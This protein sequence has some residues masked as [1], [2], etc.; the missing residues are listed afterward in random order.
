[1]KFVRWS[2]ALIITAAASATFAD[3]LTLQQAVAGALENN[4]QVRIA[5]ARQ[6]QAIA[7]QTE[8]R[9]MWLPH[10]DVSETL[11]STNN[12]VYV[13][14]SLLEQGR[15]GAQNFDPHFLNQPPVSR[16]HRLGLKVRYTV[17]D[18]FRRLETTRQAA[19][20][21]AQSKSGVDETSQ[22][23]RLDVI[24]K[25]YG[26]LVAQARH[27]VALDAV[28]TAEHDAQSMREKFREGLL[29]ESDALAAE[30]QVA[31]FRQ[32]EIEAAGGVVIARAALN[33]ALG[34]DTTADTVAAGTLPES[35]FQDSPIGTLIETGANKRGEIAAARLASDN[36][37]LQVKIARGSLLPRIDT[38][39]SWGASGSSFG[40]RSGDR[41]IGA[42]ISFDVFDG[43]KLSRL[44][45]AQSGI[46]ESRAAADAARSKVEIEIVSAHEHVRSAAQRIVVA[47]AAVAQAEAAARIVR[48]RYEQGLTTI[49]EHLHAQTAL[50]GARLNLLGA[51][52]DYI[53][54]SGDLARATGDLHDIDPFD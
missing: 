31:S 40:N 7:A 50:V 42:V 43:G 47:T 35:H 41:T 5:A 2:A 27:G 32:Q 53:V 22:A 34:R 30:V 14:G 51:R 16:N 20:A 33:A 44:A 37:R 19:N 48:D 52:Y 26:L 4:P 1:M 3:Q 38:F 46:E 8:T 28:R 23:I 15:F 39:A 45:Q 54:S 6:R 9:A 21:V 29:V 18:Q 25:F 10:V 17:F 49:T 11:M 13:F 12:P 36:A 24:A